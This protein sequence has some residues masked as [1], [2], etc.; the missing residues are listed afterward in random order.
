MPGTPPPNNASGF[1]QV[2]ASQYQIWAVQ[3][4]N[5][6]GV[7][8]DLVLKVMQAESSGGSSFNSAPNNN[9]TIDVGPMQL[10]S[11][12]FTG[13]NGTYSVPGAGN[14]NPNDPQDNVNGGVAQL[15]YLLDHYNGDQTKAVAAY[16][17][18][19]GAVD[20]AIAQ[21]G[22][23][24]NAH[25]KNP[26]YV[27][28]V[29]GPNNTPPPANQNAANVTNPAPGANTP[30]PDPLN[31][32]VVPYR[33]LH[34]D[35]ISTETALALAPPSAVILTAPNGVSSLKQ[36]PWYSNPNELTGN[37]SIH[38]LG[39]PVSFQIVTDRGTGTQ[40]TDDGTPTGKPILIRLNASM[41][42]YNLQS[43]HI[44]NKQPSRTGIHLTFWGMN[45][46]MISGECSTGL[47]MNQFGITSFLNVSK[48][49]SEAVQLISNAFGGGAIASLSSNPD[50]LRIAAQDAFV[51]FL[52]LFKNN[53]VTWYH[54]QDY[55]QNNGTAPDQASAVATGTQTTQSQ[56]AFS[57]KTGT[58]TY[59]M[60]ALN[61]EVYT[62]GYVVM[63]FRSNSY[64]G[65]FKSLSWVIDADTPYRW[66]FQF[67]FQ[68]ERTLSL[69]YYPYP[70]IGGGTSVSDGTAA[71]LANTPNL[72]EFGEE[73]NI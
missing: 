24:Y 63:N 19:A 49:N 27:T 45:A 53:G 72:T 41:K 68:I 12:N 17:N 40:L 13:P 6:Y 52:S 7:P 8:S 31:H 57:P 54:P 5:G 11:A 36:T 23:D 56:S 55:T 73:V 30:N 18:G 26:G 1:S 20:A 59:Q 66:N 21:Y 42:S 15:G 38:R 64:L 67:V 62:R 10:N 4:A 44:I 3:A 71:A 69:V 29:L 60:K 33:D 32:T 43:S 37:P 70:A 16:N 50:S 2:S 39:Y 22:D 34:L 47:F 25:L 9:N 46:D 14:Y 48:V 28:G 35:P 65:F 51:E 61:N 58:T